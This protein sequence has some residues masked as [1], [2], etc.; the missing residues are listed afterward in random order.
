MVLNKG[1]DRTFSYSLWNVYGNIIQRWLK[2][3]ITV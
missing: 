2:L 3:D 1:A